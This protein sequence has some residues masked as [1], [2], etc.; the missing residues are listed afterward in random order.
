MNRSDLDI[1]AVDKYASEI[2]ADEITKHNTPL[3]LLYS[4]KEATSATSLTLPQL[5]D[6]YGP[7]PTQTAIFGLC[8]DNLPILLDFSDPVSGSIIIES[9]P[10][11][12]KTNLLKSILWSLVKIN[13]PSEVGK[14][15]S[16]HKIF[17]TLSAGE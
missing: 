9:P 3:D 16:L 5:L 7:F 6:N 13:H 10:D 2:L 4:S 14:T 11:S 12:G 15:A 1:K 8:E 17:F